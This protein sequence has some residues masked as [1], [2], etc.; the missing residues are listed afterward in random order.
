MTKRRAS[1]TF[2]PAQLKQLRYLANLA[3]N[4]ALQG[5]NYEKQRYWVWSACHNCDIREWRRGA[6]EALEFLAAHN[7]HNTYHVGELMTRP[8]EDY[9]QCSRSYDHKSHEW[10]PEGLRLTRLCQGR[11]T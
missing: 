9:R 2:Y 8:F 5:P 1:R 11:P 10:L 4:E 3:T 6:I 7:R